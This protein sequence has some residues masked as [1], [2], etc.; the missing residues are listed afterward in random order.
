MQDLCRRIQEQTRVMEKALSDGR[1]QDFTKLISVRR[2]LLEELLRTP[3]FSRMDHPWISPMLRR[4]Q[5]WLACIRENK[6]DVTE[7]LRRARWKRSSLSRLHGAY[8]A[9]SGGGNVIRRKG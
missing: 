2:A 5:Q 6:V 1:I 3:G 8:A 7:K 4:N 9:N